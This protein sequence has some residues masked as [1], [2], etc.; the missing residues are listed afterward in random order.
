MSRDNRAKKL[1]QQQGIPY[2]EALRL[3]RTDGAKAHVLNQKLLAL[4]KKE[5]WDLVGDHIQYRWGG[6]IVAGRVFDDEL[7]LPSPPQVE[8]LRIHVMDVDY[9]A[10][11]WR[12][13][14]STGTGVQSGYVTVPARVGLRG[15]AKTA[16]LPDDP[17]MRVVDEYVDESTVI[18][19][20]ERNVVLRWHCVL[21]PGK[22][23]DLLFG[24]AEPQSSHPYPAR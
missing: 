6:G 13:V 7:R 22:D 14:E 20:L 23:P 11:A 1:A 16:N 8:Q 24:Q 12:P 18:V 15:E 19:S 2:A 17:T 9:D 3:T 4:V 5:C 21:V 10:L